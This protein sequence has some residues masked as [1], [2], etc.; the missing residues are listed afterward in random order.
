M[1]SE[2]TPPTTLKGSVE[3]QE[4][5]TKPRKEKKIKPE[6]QLAQ[7]Y[8][9]LQEL[10]GKNYSQIKRE[11]DNVKYHARKYD[12]D[13]TK[14]IEVFSEDFFP[15]CEYRGIDEKVLHNMQ[16][17]L[18]EFFR[19]A[20][21]TDNQVVDGIKEFSHFIAYDENFDTA[22]YFESTNYRFPDLEKHLN[23]IYKNTE[24]YSSN[25]N[26]YYDALADHLHMLYKDKAPDAV[27]KYVKKQKQQQN[28]KQDSD[29]EDGWFCT[30]IK[31][32]T[33]AAVSD[34]IDICLKPLTQATDRFFKKRKEKK[35]SFEY[36]IDEDEKE[37]LLERF[38]DTTLLNFDFNTY[39]LD[40]LAFAKP[41][42]LNSFET[43]PA[44]FDD[45]FDVIQ[46]EQ[47]VESQQAQQLPLPEKTENSNINKT[48]IV[49]LP[50]NN[51]D[52]LSSAIRN[53]LTA[54]FDEFAFSRGYV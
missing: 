6:I 8:D 20:K 3:Y 41:D 36:I 13:Y 35:N 9:Y 18:M 7:D 11:L 39:N 4:T 38:K 50:T 40:N 48:T 53:E 47:T 27:N 32:H 54:F 2:N 10:T 16:I 44:E 19:D 42:W 12:Y 22:K 24:D 37:E 31:N 23:Y 21:A 5:R 17:A 15:A 25:P 26:E 1:I 30:L 34:V 46:M 14:L 29:K 28:D 52:S 45:D 51:S 33:P 43:E 49:K